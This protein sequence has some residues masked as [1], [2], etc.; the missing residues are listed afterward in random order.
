MHYASGFRRLII[1]EIG[2]FSPTTP[3]GEHT[4]EYIGEHVGVA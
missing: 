4:G 1:L 3:F 2:N